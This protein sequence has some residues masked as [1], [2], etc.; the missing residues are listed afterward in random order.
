MKSPYFFILTTLLALASPALS[1]LAS[2]PPAKPA[3]SS[4]EPRQAGKASPPESVEVQTRKGGR[5]WEVYIKD[6]QHVQQGQT[7]FKIA[8]QAPTAVHPGHQIDY[9]VAKQSYLKILALQKAGKT[10]A[11]EVATAKFQMQMA[12]KLL[13]DAPH[14][15]QFHY[16]DAPIS[17]TL[18]NVSVQNQ[19]QANTVLATITADPAPKPKLMVARD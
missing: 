18:S 9:D 13:G 2:G 4:P 7:M 12:A 14:Q 10:S 3:H 15:V 16:V 11:N 19:L 17:G 1:S 8:T 5:V 6:G